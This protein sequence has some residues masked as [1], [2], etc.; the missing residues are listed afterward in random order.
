[1]DREPSRSSIVARR[2]LKGRVMRAHTLFGLLV[3]SACGGTGGE[4][5][6]SVG[7]DQSGNPASIDIGFNGGPDQFDDFPIFFGASVPAAP[8]LCHTYLAWDVA[9]EASGMGN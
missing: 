9:S 3:L 1:M 7:E 4:D 5:A 2:L 8:R 6:Q